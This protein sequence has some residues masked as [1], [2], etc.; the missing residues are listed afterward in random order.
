MTNQQIE[1]LILRR[2]KQFL[3]HS[4]LYY[5]CN[6]NLIS[7]TTYDKWCKELYQLQKEY[8]EIAAKVQYHDICSKLDESGS[9]YYIKE[10]PIEIMSVALRLLALNKSV[11]SEHF[12]A[13]VQRYG[14]RVLD[15]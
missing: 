2:R 12:G 4:F 9:G 8:P 5:K 1:E 13:F 11:A 6:E 7:D 10:Y 14:L 3:V 15:K